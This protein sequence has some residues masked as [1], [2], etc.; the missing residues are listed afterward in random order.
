MTVTCLSK[1]LELP[2]PEE[3]E[4]VPDADGEALGL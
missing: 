3:K 1:Q 2:F 4:T